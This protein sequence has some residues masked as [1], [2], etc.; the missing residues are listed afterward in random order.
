MSE[1]RR[2]EMDRAEAALKTR[3]E[4]EKN[5]AEAT[6]RPTAEAA[7]RLIDEAL[8]AKL[9]GVMPDL[10]EGWTV[11][12][13]QAE[14]YTPGWRGTN[15][16]AAQRLGVFVTAPAEVAPDGIEDPQAVG[17]ATVGARFHYPE[18]Y[19]YYQSNSPDGIVIEV[20]YRH[21]DGGGRSHQT[22]RYRKMEVDKAK[23]VADMLV[24]E[25]VQKVYS[26]RSQ[27]RAA[28]ATKRDTT[29]VERLTNN[30]KYAI[31]RIAGVLP[32]GAITIDTNWTSPGRVKFTLSGTAEN[33]ER[34]LKAAVAGEGK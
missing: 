13:V 9:T 30:Y 32:D 11:E 25:A 33:I 5:A 29:E 1:T 7:I 15:L 23:A 12:I 26:T 21:H 24:Q 6:H 31:A 22:K 14:G 27:R 18:H 28:R 3:R 8:R 20:E 4:R 2:E 16:P 19:G 34:L 17:Q 10:P